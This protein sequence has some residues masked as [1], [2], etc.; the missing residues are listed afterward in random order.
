MVGEYAYILENI[1]KQHGPKTI[2]DDVTLAFFFGTKIGVI[3]ANG[4]GKSS[5]LRILAGIDT[6][7]AGEAQI[8][9]N[10][11]IGYLEQEPQFDLSKPYWRL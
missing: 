3:G 8:A 11:T 9:K 4:S 5:L 10:R 7:F 1:T 2:L 6:D